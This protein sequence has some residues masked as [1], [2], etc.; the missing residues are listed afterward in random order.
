MTNFLFTLL[1][2]E[3]PIPGQLFIP[4]P[5]GN[6]CGQ[7]CSD[8]HFSCDGDHG[9]VIFPDKCHCLKGTVLDEIQN[10]CVPISKCSKI[11][12]LIYYLDLICLP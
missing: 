10:K 5:A 3:C 12:H 1:Y 4:V 2:I 6:D 8:P 9:P 11:Q 7:T